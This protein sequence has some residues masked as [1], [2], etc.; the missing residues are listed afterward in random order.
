MKLAQSA[1]IA[2]ALGVA[3][4]I[5]IAGCGSGR[6][7]TIPVP[8]MHEVN[9][10]VEL[11]DQEVGLTDEQRLQVRGIVN[12]NAEMKH[13]IR[14]Q[15]TGRPAEWRDADKS[16][17]RKLDNRMRGMLAGDQLGAWDALFKDIY[18]KEMDRHERG[19]LPQDRRR[20]PKDY[21]PGGF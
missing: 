14:Q 1:L 6:K 9:A 13:R 12:N 20:R 16:R 4:M 15:Y 2:P 19:T 7:T 21:G 18:A 11:I 17:L 5:V 3:A 8:P 10:M